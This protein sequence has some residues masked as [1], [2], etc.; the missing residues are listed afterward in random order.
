MAHVF[1]SYSSKHRDLTEKLAAFLESCGLDVWW[2]KELHARRD[3]DW[4]I[5]DELRKAGCVLVVWSEG[6]VA[7]DWV[8]K[9]AAYGRDH[10]RLVCAKA[11]TLPADRIPEAFR[12]RDAHKLD[13]ERD[14]ILRDVLAVREG[15]LLLEDK[16]E[17]LPPADQ[18]TPTTLLQAKYGLVPFTGGEA[19]RDELIDWALARGPY[20]ERAR[21]DTGRLIHGPGGLGKTRLMIEVAEALRAEGWSAGFLARPGAGDEPGDTAEARTRRRE[22]RAKALARLIRGASDKGL[23]LIMDYAEGREPEIAALAAAIRGRPAD[24]TRPI[25]LVLLTRGAGDWWTRLVEDDPVVAALFGAERLAVT[26]LG[27]VAGGE[28]RVALFRAAV[29]AFAPRLAEMGYALPA[30]GD[31]AP[32]LARVGET[33]PKTGHQ[34]GE[35]YDRPLAIAMEALLHLAV[36]TPPGTNVPSVP[37]LLAGILGLEREHWAKLVPP[38]R[39]E[40]GALVAA[41]VADLERAV[42]QITAVQGVEGRRAAEDLLIADRYYGEQR[43]SRASVRE[44]T[45]NTSKIYGRGDLIAQLE[46]DLIG[47]HHVGRVGDEELLDGCLEWIAT[48]PDESKR[49]ARYRDLITV[50]QRASRPEHGK[51]GVTRASALLDRL[52]LTHGEVLAEPMIAVMLDTPGALL[53]RL[54]VLIDRLPEPALE[55]INFALPSGHVAWWELSLRVAERYAALARSWMRAAESAAITGAERDAA[56]NRAAA[57]LNTL[58]GRLTMGRRHEEALAASKEAVDI[59]RALAKERPDAFL[60]GLAAYLT[61]LGNCLSAIGRR[62]EALA[63]AQEA[64]DITRALAKE[65][66]DA[67]R[68]ELA[69]SLNN[70][71]NCLSDLGRREEALAAAQEAVD[72]LRLLAKEQPDSDLRHLAIGLMPLG[73]RLSELGRRE[74]ALAAAKEAVDIFRPLAKERPDAFLPDLAALLINLHIRLSNL[75]RRAEA[76]VASKEF[77]DIY[78]ALAKDWP[79][80]FLP[81]LAMSLN[82]LVG[83]LSNLGR[84]EEALA[85]AQEAVAV[86]RT[87]ARGRPDTFLPDLAM[88][89]KNLGGNLFSLGHR[90]EALAASQEAVDIYR[91]LAK[92]RPDVFLPDFGRSLGVMS[93]TL[94]GAGRQG[95]A[96]DC[97]WEGLDAI[98]PLVEA[99]PQVFGDLARNLGRDYRTACEKAGR[100]PDRALLARFARALKRSDPAAEAALQARIEAIIKEAERT[101]ALDEAALAEL[102]PQ[103]A[104][105]LRARLAA[106]DET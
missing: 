19:V 56:L 105:H 79:N 36:K 44:V 11:N 71:G 37:N 64:V 93:Q 7:S 101:G 78:R 35:G 98:A 61:T 65:R 66:P 60:P 48:E 75:G 45:D 97:A 13:A 80:A 27:G 104:Q 31:L 74:E 15:R 92:D 30:A 38:L 21:R 72:I 16:R 68:P 57:G 41:R 94:A 91:A 2:D 9:E 89:L 96:A 23:L 62:E 53:S 1:I 82:E 81:Y 63:A 84:H 24:D 69:A 43:L 3:F 76:L 77:V 95:E 40:T 29:E 67:S 20:A 54:E 99:Q 12:K 55:A 86:Y 22:R 58:G 106:R 85:A 88:R 4:Q 18:R 51:E 14:L 100:D 34:A 42:G 59:T 46:P 102:S 87:L 103:L 90:E 52:L 32:L 49:A 6:A 70:L 25:R 17:D 50:L 28:E 10:D 5:G 26:A 73:N 47:E 83:N 8:L 33:G 39:D